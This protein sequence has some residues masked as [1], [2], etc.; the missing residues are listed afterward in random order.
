MRI[1]KAMADMG[2]SS[3][4]G[5]EKLVEEGRV[6]VNGHPAQIGQE[7]NP[8]R[9]ILHVDG[10][11]I[12]RRNPLQKAEV[13]VAVRSDH[14][15][16]RVARQRRSVEVAGAER[17]RAAGRAGQYQ[18]VGVPTGHRQARH[19]M[20]IGPRPRLRRGAG[21]ARRGLRD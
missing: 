20:R 16:A 17:E 4:R 3:R 1:H 21:R 10:E 6:T 13:G 8:T 9:V 19:R 14:G 2:V 12:A 18:Y 7:I 5:S 11:R 15:V